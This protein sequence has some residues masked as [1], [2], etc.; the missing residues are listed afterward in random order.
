LNEGRSPPFHGVRVSLGTERRTLERGKKPTLSRRTCIPR[1]R[2]RRPDR[3]KHI[4]VGA[5]TFILL[6]L[7]WKVHSDRSASSTACFA[8]SS[9]SFWRRFCTSSS[10]G[11]FTPSIAFCD[12]VV[13]GLNA[14]CKR[15]TCGSERGGVLAAAEINK[16]T[17][18]KTGSARAISIPSLAHT[19]A[20]GTLPSWSPS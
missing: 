12:L 5:G 18:G 11:V 14:N 8:A 3:V 15:A 17:P 16:P 10:S 2:L 7:G 19:P 9:T 6:I 20:P 13:S 1:Y 4:I